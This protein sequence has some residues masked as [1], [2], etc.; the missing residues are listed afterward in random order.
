MHP[1]LRMPKT[2]AGYGVFAAVVVLL[3]YAV[4]TPIWLIMHGWTDHSYSQLIF[5]VIIQTFGWGV[6]VMI[7]SEVLRFLRSPR[8]GPQRR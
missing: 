6:F 2:S 8:K 3:F 1:A 7:V 4:W 5:P